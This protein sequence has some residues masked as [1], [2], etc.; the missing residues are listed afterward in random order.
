MAAEHQYFDIEAPNDFTIGMRKALGK[1]VVEF[2]RRRTESGKDKNDKRFIK[3]SKAYI[4]SKAFKIAGKS[5]SK[6]NLTL[7]G[8]MLIA[9]DVL[10]HKEGPISIG[11][12]EGSEENARADG[13][14]KKRDFMG[15][16]DKDLN[17]LI[18]K[19]RDNYGK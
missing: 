10:S 9:L 2:I 1:E 12:K 18:D 11:F 4:N 8:D 15:I 6:V 17:K 14:V 7:S 13:N 16:K 19:V 5:P 3:Y